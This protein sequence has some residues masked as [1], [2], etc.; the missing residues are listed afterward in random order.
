VLEEAEKWRK[1]VFQVTREVY[2]KD[3]PLCSAIE[4]AIWVS[5][6]PILHYAVRS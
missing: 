6:L 1:G 2:E 3:E 4:Q 5:V